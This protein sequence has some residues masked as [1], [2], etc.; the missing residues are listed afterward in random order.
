MLHKL[1]LENILNESLQGELYKQHQLRFHINENTQNLVAEPVLVGPRFGVAVVHRHSLSQNQQ[2]PL[3]GKEREA[4]RTKNDYQ[5]QSGPH[6]PQRPHLTRD[7]KENE[8]KKGEEIKARG[9]ERQERGQRRL[10]ER[11]KQ[12]TATFSFRKFGRTEMVYV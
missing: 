9:G 8:K 11:R 10:K 7:E 6:M 5:R 4:G 12:R 3:R 2:R 1:L